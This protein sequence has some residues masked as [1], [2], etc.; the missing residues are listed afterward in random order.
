MN[1]RID[2]FCLSKKTGIAIWVALAIY[3]VYQISMLSYSPMPWFDEVYF[4]SIT[5]AWMNGEGFL[6]KVAAT[7]Q[8]HETTAAYGPI[9]FWLTSFTV[10]FFG[11]NSFGIRIISL[12]AG[13]L[14]TIITY[15]YLS[16]VTTKA[17]GLILVLLLTFDPFWNVCLK[18]GRMDLV[19]VTFILIGLS[20]V[21][22][23]EQ[24]T[25]F[26]NLLASALLFG[27]SMLTNP[28]SG[29]VLIPVL[30]LIIWQLAVVHKSHILLITFLSPIAILYSSWVFIGFGGFT[31]WYSFYAGLLAGGDT[32]AVHGYLGG[33][34]YIP[35]HEWLLIFTTLICLALKFRS[36]GRSAFDW[37]DLT[38]LS[39]L[40]CYYLF[41]LDWGPYS[42]YVI[43]FYY[44][45]IIKSLSGLPIKA[46]W[47]IAPLLMLNLAFVGTKSLYEI[48]S[49][50]ARKTAQIESF[51]NLHIP[52]GSKVIGSEAFYYINRNAGNAYE[53]SNR[54]GTD[55]QRAEALKNQFGYDYLIIGFDEK[56]LQPE[57]AQCFLKNHRLEKIAVFEKKPTEFSNLLLTLPFFNSIEKH[58]YA[59]TIYRRIKR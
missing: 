57:V 56:I 34:G 52:K 12:V 25:E 42:V 48:S 53:L 35:K 28:R 21:Y 26:K 7:L 29:I 9:Y 51:I 11:F 32:T 17:M 36:N 1:N 14:C 38:I 20:L 16:K 24:H 54:C 45:L 13:A 47:I 49:L 46:V 59:C 39:Y 3:W 22:R 27:L 10:K 5:D 23:K 30:V 37:F 6:P 18:Q 55:S 50:E 33:R 31:D 2:R 4:A 15:T 41:V 19:C 44:M 40:I 43:P 8:R 58:A